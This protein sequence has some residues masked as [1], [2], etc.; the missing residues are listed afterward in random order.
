M[1]TIREMVS[2]SIADSKGLFGRLAPFTMA[3]ILPKSRVNIVAIQ[4][5]SLNSTMRIMIAS[6]FSLAMVAITSALSNSGFADQCQ[7]HSFNSPFRR[8]DD[9]Y[10]GT[11]HLNFFTNFWYIA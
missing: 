3:P 11:C 4:L 9:L 8:F 1:K 7:T 2:R 10:T 6:V 5:D